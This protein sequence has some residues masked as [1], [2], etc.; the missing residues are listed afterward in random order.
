MGRGGWGSRVKENKKCENNVIQWNR[1][2]L[3]SI[4]MSSLQAKCAIYDV[5]SHE[6]RTNQ[7]TKSFTVNY[8][9]MDVHNLIQWHCYLFVLLV[10]IAL[11]CHF[12]FFFRET[13][14]RIKYQCEKPI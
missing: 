10:D 1:A 5:T 2:K 6:Q 11:F 7:F 8:T 9:V 4:L 14:S 3:L 13:L 12:Y